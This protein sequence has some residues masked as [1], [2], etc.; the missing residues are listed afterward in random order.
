MVLHDVLYKYFVALQPPSVSCGIAVDE[1]LNLILITKLTEMNRVTGSNTFLL[2]I[3]NESDTI[4]F[5]QEPDII[6]KVRSPIPC[7]Y[8]VF[9]TV[10]K[11][12][13]R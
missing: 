4:A 8:G 3:Q 2:T 5:I 6:Y 9:Y 10:Y 1:G 11:C 13:T 7:V 12:M